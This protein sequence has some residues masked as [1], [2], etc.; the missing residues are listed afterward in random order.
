MGAERCNRHTN[1]IDS[2]CKIPEMVTMTKSALTHMNLRGYLD[3]LN[4]PFQHKPF[5]VSMIISTTAADVQ[6]WGNCEIHIHDV[7]IAGKVHL[8]LQSQRNS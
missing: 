6:I 7:K 3:D 8:L 1:T 4:S 2:S 5:C